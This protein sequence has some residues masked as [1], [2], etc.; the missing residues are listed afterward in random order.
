MSFGSS[1]SHRT[2]SFQHS[3]IAQA[4]TAMTSP[5]GFW[6][7]ASKR[8]K[9]RG[10]QKRIEQYSNNGRANGKLPFSAGLLVFSPR[11]EHFSRS[12][13]RGSIKLYKLAYK[14]ESQKILTKCFTKFIWHLR[15]RVVYV[16]RKNNKSGPVSGSSHTPDA[17][18][19][20]MRGGHSHSHR[21][22]ALRG[23]LKILRSR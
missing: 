22:S 14:P 11:R 1:C 3:S 16:L 21:P 6:L 12:R 8:R 20:G 10:T 18:R 5:Y 2:F 19:G 7:L 13:S 4:S 23:A 9:K 15:L 17:G